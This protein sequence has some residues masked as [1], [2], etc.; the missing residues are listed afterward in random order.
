MKRLILL[1]ITILISTLIV[2]AQIVL[3]HT[4][5]VPPDQTFPG[6]CR[7]ENGGEKW[8]IPDVGNHRIDLYNLDYTLFKTINIPTQPNQYYGVMY[9]S[10]KLFDLDDALEFMVADFY[11]TRVM[12][13]KEDGSNIFAE[14]DSANPAKV[15]YAEPIIN[16]TGGTKMVIGVKSLATGINISE[17]YRL[18]GT[19]LSAHAESHL[20]NFERIISDIFPNP[21]TGRMRIDYQLL[22]GESQ[23]QI[24]FYNLQG[25]LVKSFKADGQSGYLEVDNSDLPSGTYLYQISTTKSSSETKKMIL[26]R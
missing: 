16:T 15:S 26:I 21:N 25:K 5:P 23:G 11:Q 7:L 18:P 24:S 3:D 17:I 9:I 20:S 4:Y 2:N 14:G 1:S 19:L 13:Y 10:D 8:F 6:I 12:V 22:Q